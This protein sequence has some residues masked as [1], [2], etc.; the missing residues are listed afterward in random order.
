MQ[1]VL[2]GEIGLRGNIGVN[3]SLEQRLPF[4][5][6]HF[7]EQSLFEQKN[8][9]GRVEIPDEPRFL[10]GVP[11]EHPE[12][13]GGDRT[14]PLDDLEC[15]DK[16]IVRVG[17]HSACIRTEAEAVLIDKLSLWIDEAR[18]RLKKAGC[19]RSS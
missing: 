15:S 7:S 4:E 13:C 17:V 18:H 14:H 5:L 6:H 11:A 1:S 16:G 9:I 2:I 19:N 3:P 10:E 8:P 12:D